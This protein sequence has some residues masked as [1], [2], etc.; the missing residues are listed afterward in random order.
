MQIMHIFKCDIWFGTWCFALKAI[1]FLLIDIRSAVNRLCCLDPLHIAVVSLLLCLL[2]TLDMF[3]LW[4]NNFSKVTEESGS[5]IVSN[6]PNQVWLACEN[7]CLSWHFPK[8]ISMMIFNTSM[9][10]ALTIIT[11]S[12]FTEWGNRVACDRKTEWTDVC[13]VSR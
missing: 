8:I 6:K 4:E 5:L 11:C 1:T 12:W 9:A 7:N 13:G 3:S 10:V 2:D